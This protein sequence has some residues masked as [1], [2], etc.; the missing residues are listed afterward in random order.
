MPELMRQGGDAQG[1]YALHSVLAESL[2]L[3]SLGWFA[4]LA[5]LLALAAAWT[6]SRARVAGDDDVDARTGH[7]VFLVG[8]G[9]VLSLFVPALI[10]QHYFV[11]A[12]PLLAFALRPAARTA[13]NAWPLRVLAVASWA[14]IAMEALWRLCGWSPAGAALAVNAGALLLFALA[15]LEAFRTRTQAA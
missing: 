10:W 3:R 8:I 15:V 11:L 12:L 6:S 5:A 9:A 13:G 1:N 7:D 14:L 2:G 4:P